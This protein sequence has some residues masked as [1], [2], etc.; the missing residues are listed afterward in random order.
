MLMVV[1]IDCGK[2]RITTEGSHSQAMI[3]T[4]KSQIKANA[5][6]AG[7]IKGI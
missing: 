6:A 5:P 7:T 3:D 1:M 4:P 2:G